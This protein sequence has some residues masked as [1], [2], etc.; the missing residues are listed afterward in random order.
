MR[1]DEAAA[2]QRQSTVDRLSITQAFDVSAA[3]PRATQ[4]YNVE[5]VP[6]HDRGSLTSDKSQD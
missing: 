4:A 1:R 6:R 5:T 3:E 2:E